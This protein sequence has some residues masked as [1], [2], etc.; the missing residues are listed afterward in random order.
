LAV[1][2]GGLVI[3]FDAVLS[4][5]AKIKAN[6]STGPDYIYSRVLYELQYEIATPFLQIFECSFESKGLPAD[7]KWAN[8]VPIFKKRMK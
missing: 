3:T 2:T 6:R 8:V 5:L 4:K 7:W 1:D